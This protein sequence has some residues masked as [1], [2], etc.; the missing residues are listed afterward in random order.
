MASGIDFLSSLNC[1]YAGSP[2]ISSVAITKLRR[3]S[4]EHCFKLLGIS[5]MFIF[6]YIF[7]RICK[8]FLNCCSPHGT[9]HRWHEVTG[10]GGRVL[11]EPRNTII[12]ISS[13]SSSL[14]P[15]STSYLIPSVHCNHFQAEGHCMPAVCEVL[16][17]VGEVVP[18][19][20]CDTGILTRDT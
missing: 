11:T 4:L 20:L 8:L 7:H 9:K 18:L 5:V 10:Q 14:L 1:V 17:G 6:K 3:R 16:E 13:S 15:P 12:I 19:L 2:A